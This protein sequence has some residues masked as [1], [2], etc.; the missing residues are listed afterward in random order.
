MNANL[1]GGEVMPTYRHLTQG[2]TRLREVR[3]LAPALVEAL[4]AE[5]HKLIEDPLFVEKLASIEQLA[6]RGRELAVTLG[7]LAGHAAPA[8]ASGNFMVGGIVPN[9]NYGY[10]AGNPEQFGARAIRELVGLAPDI[11]ERVAK[12]FRSTESIVCAIASAKE[13]GLDG[14]AAKLEAKL[15]ASLDDDPSPA[16]PTHK[17][18]SAAPAEPPANHDA[19]TESLDA[20]AAQ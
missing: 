5:F 1:T 20:E 19:P 13:K 2:A 7:D 3:P 16:A 4:R 17:H 11:A 8:T 10:A 12:A 15:L 18:K 9:P 14:L 6:A